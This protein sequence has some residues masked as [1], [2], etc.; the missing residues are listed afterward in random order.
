MKVITICGSLSKIDK[1]YWDKHAENESLKGNAIYTVN[2]WNK[3][4]WLHS[5]EGKNQKEILDNLHKNKITLSD[6]VHILT[7][8]DGYLGESTLSEIGHALLHKK[9]IKIFVCGLEQLWEM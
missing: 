4:N 5:P 9:E 7:T 6:E 1:L 3:Y 2:V 8:Q